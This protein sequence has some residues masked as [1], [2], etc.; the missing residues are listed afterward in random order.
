MAKGSSVAWL[1]RQVVLEE[2]EKKGVVRV[3]DARGKAQPGNCG[4]DSIE[5]HRGARSH[6]RS[7]TLGGGRWRG[8]VNAHV[9]DA[10]VD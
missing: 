7:E 10:S 8:G 9:T 2:D 4:Y 6:C 3:V 5:A 1:A